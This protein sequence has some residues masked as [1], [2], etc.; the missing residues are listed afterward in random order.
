MLLLMTKHVAASN[1]LLV[2]LSAMAVVGTR[3]KSTNTIMWSTDH[4][5]HHVAKASLNFISDSAELAKVLV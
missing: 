1:A 3:P 5:S 4:I 2:R